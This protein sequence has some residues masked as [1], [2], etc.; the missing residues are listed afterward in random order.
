MLDELWHILGGDHARFLPGS[1]SSVSSSFDAL[2]LY[3][4]CFSLVFVIGIFSV[5][6]V[7][8]VRYRRR[9]P[10]QL[11][12]EVRDN[13]GLEV[14][15]TLIPFGFLLVG[16]FWGA[17]QYIEAGSPNDGESVYV[18]AKQW[19][20]KFEHENGVSEIN[21]LHV[22][23][24]H[25]IRLVMISQD[26]IHSFFVPEFRVKFDVLPG[27]YTRAWFQAS[28][29]GSSRIL[30]TQYC[31]TDHSR[32]TGSVI[33]MTPSDYA[34][35][36]TR[37]STGIKLSETPVQHGENVYRKENCGA[38]HNG[39]N[40]GAPSLNG[41]FGRIIQLSDDR[42]VAVDENYL[43]RS[44]LDPN[45]EIVRGYRPI[46]PTYAGQ[47][48]ETDLIDLIIYIRS[49]KPSSV[50]LSQKDASYD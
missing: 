36:Q 49:M 10:S 31:G 28:S 16:F 45:S 7:F 4:L 24:G 38:C 32:M 20:W 44:I 25:N 18:Y 5:M 41:I 39:D 15:W 43:R 19:M 3:L 8:C 30:C 40:P 22:P 29:V 2:T 12:F 6:V 27:R 37:M 34:A 14:A 47:L 42:S 46:M 23:F 21:E 26:V 33:S 17:H 9:T 48:S 13:Y 35:W 1:M 11:A 50:R